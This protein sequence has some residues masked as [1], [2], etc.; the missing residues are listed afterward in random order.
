MVLVCRLPQA[1]HDGR[2]KKTCSR[3]KQGRK[4]KRGWRGCPPPPCGPAP[5][6]SVRGSFDG[7]K[8]GR[9]SK[10]NPRKREEMRGGRRERA[11]SKRLK[12]RDFIRIYWLQAASVT[13]LPPWLRSTQERRRRRRQREEEAEGGTL[14]GC[15]FIENIEL[16]LKLKQ[17]KSCKS[18]AAFLLSFILTVSCLRKPFCN[19]AWR[20]S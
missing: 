20:H 6:G 19:S 2:G 3:V 4:V 17:G 15:F 9:E 7:F 11:G 8:S 1:K 16:G 12:R 13:S 18:R 10:Q 14:S 5:S